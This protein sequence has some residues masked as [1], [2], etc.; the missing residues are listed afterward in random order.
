MPDDHRSPDA[1]DSAVLVVLVAD[2]SSPWSVDELVCECKDRVVVEDGLGYRLGGQ[3]IHA[4]RDPY[5]HHRGAPSSA[6][7]DP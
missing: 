4:A 7:G 5:T 1:D 3:A 2:S 6:F